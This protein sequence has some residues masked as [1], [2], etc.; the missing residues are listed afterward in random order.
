MATGWTLEQAQRLPIRWYRAFRHYWSTVCPMPA[1]MLRLLAQAHG[2][3]WPP[4]ENTTED[5]LEL[6]QIPGVW[7]NP[8]PIIA[9]VETVI[10]EG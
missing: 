3:Q 2:F 5:P 6:A 9:K 4:L 8:E 7:L 10:I 1:V